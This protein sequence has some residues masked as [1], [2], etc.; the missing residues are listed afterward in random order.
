[1]ATTLNFKLGIDIP[2]WRPISPLTAATGAGMSLAW[3][4][5]SDATR[6][7]YIYFLRSATALEVYSPIADDWIV[8]ASPALT[9]TFGAGATAIFHPSQGPRGVIA[10]GSTTTTVPLTTALPAAVGLNQLANKGDGVGFRIRIIGNSAGSSGKIEERWI[11]G[12]TAGTT[13]TLT[14]DTPLSFTPASGDAY[15]ILS[16]RVF[17]LSAG[18]LAAGMWKYY[19]VAT[20]SY[21]GNLATTNL[22]ATVSTDTNGLVLS[23][24]HVSYDRTPGTGFVSGGATYNGATMN[25]IQ[26]TAAAAGTITGS[27]MPADLR[28]NEYRN[29]Q[30]RIV[31]DTTTPT[32]VGQR[33]VIASHTSG[34]TGVFTLGS[35]WTVTPSSSAKFV[36]ENNDDL[37]LLR[38]SIS[39]SVYSYSISGNAWSTVTFTASGNTSGQGVVFEQAFGIARD[40]THNRLHGHLFCIR[41]GAFPTIDLFDI[42]AS[43]A[44]TWSLDIAYGNK[45]QT[46]TTGTSAA[47]DPTTCGGKFLHVN[48]NGTQRFTR[49]NML[50]GL[51]EPGTYLR[52]PEGS[53][54][55]GQKCAM[56]LFIDGATKLGTLIHVTH[57]QTAAFNCM[58][59]G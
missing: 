5:R 38:S 11:I 17:M 30:V 29:F 22:P 54:V 57:A 15:E 56:A 18:V 12:N 36:I 20:N 10:A 23:E 26:A 40:P 55:A 59:Q 47:Y 21:S 25:A 24:L 42:T 49:F 13:P 1:M 51:M 8:L 4:H 6:V 48:V 14:L 50:T 44:G 3:D 41:G 43:A 9:G 37:I 39:V 16:G 2:Q 53:A 7:P 31:E 28:T 52:F 34:A 58:I 45:S 46:F 32:S 19:D 33:R 35:N 27:G